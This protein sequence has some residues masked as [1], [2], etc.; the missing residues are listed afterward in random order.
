MIL[1]PSRDSTSPNCAIRKKSRWAGDKHKWGVWA[2]TACGRGLA[3]ARRTRLDLPR[4]AAVAQRNVTSRS[5]Q[6]LTRNASEAGTSTRLIQDF[7][8][9]EPDAASTA[10]RPESPADRFRTSASDVTTSRSAKTYLARSFFPP[11][12]CTRSSR[13][14]TGTEQQRITLL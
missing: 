5:P 9:Q 7:I 4:S 2:V 11:A 6:R 14:C 3:Y 13:S 12:S 8:V 1:R 10:D